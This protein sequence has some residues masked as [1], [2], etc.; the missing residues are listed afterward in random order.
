MAGQRRQE[1]EDRSAHPGLFRATPFKALSPAASE[2]DDANN[3]PFSAPRLAP[4]MAE[5]G[6]SRSAIA[7]ATP[8]LRATT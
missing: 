8:T 1:G 6:M 4:D 7:F 5:I 3:T 2:D